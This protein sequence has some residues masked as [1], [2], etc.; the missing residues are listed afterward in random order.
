M[1]DIVPLV[2]QPIFL[3]AFPIVMLALLDWQLGHGTALLPWPS[4]LFQINI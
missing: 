3:G 4:T 1:G 2:I